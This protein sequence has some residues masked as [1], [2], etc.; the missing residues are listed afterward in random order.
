MSVRDRWWDYI[1]SEG[2]QLGYKK[3]TL[4]TL[5]DEQVQELISEELDDE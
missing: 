3:W 2:D 1:R 5:D 4:G